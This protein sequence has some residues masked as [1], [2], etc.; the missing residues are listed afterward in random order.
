[1]GRPTITL[2]ALV[3]SRSFRS[4]NQRHR[5]VLLLDPLPLPDVHPDADE[6]TRIAVRF[7]RD[8]YRPNGTFWI[9][10]FERVCREGR[11]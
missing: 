7:R 9:Q 4:D 5:R 8:P 3:E 11:P 2:A 6:L 1:V 10:A